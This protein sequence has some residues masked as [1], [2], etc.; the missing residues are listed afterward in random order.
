VLHHLVHRCQ[1]KSH[2]HHGISLAAIQHIY[3][4]HPPIAAVRTLDLE[5]FIVE[6]AGSCRGYVLNIRTRFLATTECEGLLARA[7]QNQ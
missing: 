7:V 2:N 6:L 4:N 1:G 3:R 5:G